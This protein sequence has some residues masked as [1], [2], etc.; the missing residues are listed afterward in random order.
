MG[1]IL[2]TEHWKAMIAV[3]ETTFQDPQESKA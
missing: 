1:E 3:H 2:S